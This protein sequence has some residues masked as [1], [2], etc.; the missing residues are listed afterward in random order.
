MAD[1]GIF[2]LLDLRGRAQFEFFDSAF[3]H[4]PSAISSAVST[5]SRL[6]FLS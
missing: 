4:S 2:V 5:A 1:Y 3:R 6:T